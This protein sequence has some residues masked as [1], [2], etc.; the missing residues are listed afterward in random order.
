MFKRTAEKKEL[1]LKQRSSL[2]FYKLK[3]YFNNQWYVTKKKAK[4]FVD[5]FYFYLIVFIVSLFFLHKTL[6]FLDVTITEDSLRSLAFA[7]ASIIGTSIAVIFLFSTFILQSTADLFSTQYLNKFIQD[8]KEKVF[9]WLL[10]FLTIASFFTPIFLKNYILEILIGILFIAFYL[11]YNLYKELRKRINPETT[12]IKI[13]ND[14]IY[15]LEIVNKE[16]KKKVRIQN[17]IFKFEKENNEFSL[18]MYYK[19]NHNWHVVVLENVKYLYEIGLKILAKNEINSFNLTVKYINDIYLKHLALRNAHFIRKPV[20]PWG[21]YSF[22]DEGFTTKILEYI[23]SMS[24]RVIQEKR[25]ENIYYLLNIYENILTNSLNVKY[26]DKTNDAL[27]GNPL[28][29]LILAYY[30]RFIENILLSQESDWIW[31]VV[32]SISNVSNSILNRTDHYLILK[33]INQIINKTSMSCLTNDKQAFL[34]ELV[35]IYFNQIRIAWN[36]Y[37]NNHIFWNDL[38]KELKKSVLLLSVSSNLGLLLN[39]LFINFHQ[40][41]AD[42]I[43]WITKLEDENQKKE[44]L[45][46]FIQLLEKWSNFLLDLAR[47]IGLE[48]N[49]VGLPI[50]QSI[51]NNLKIISWIKNKFIDIDL[52]EIYEDQFYTLSWYFQKTEKVEGDFLYNLEQVLEILLREINDN[53]KQGNFNIKYLI[54]LYERLV[55]QHFEKVDFGYGFNHARIILKLVFLGLFLHKYKITGL[56]DNILSKIDELNKKYLELSKEYYGLKEKKNNVLGPSKFQL[57]KELNDLENDLFSYNTGPLID[58]IRDILKKEI[59]KDEWTGFVK[60]IEY[61]KNIEYR[62]FRF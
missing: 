19:T 2:Y 61:C 56:E 39:E 16:I 10:V 44:H 43:N 17:K 60:R 49:Q 42:V 47:D 30:I 34:K 31:E 11:I 24:D 15:Q 50:I 41:Q 6:L 1:T 13:R 14:A 3:Q 18:D 33:Q 58:D 28:L 25:K 23:Q 20:S 4:I 8:V 9:F 59:T 45:N 36:K 26:A 57:C 54:E 21:N 5:S 48:G 51:D 29:N 22:D 37:E 55:E 35:N 38:F 53:L 12:L 27:K 52:D 40:W 62:N 7:V 46:K 32:K